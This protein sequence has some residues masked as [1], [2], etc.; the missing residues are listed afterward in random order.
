MFD[1]KKALSIGLCILLSGCCSEENRDKF[2]VGAGAFVAGSIITSSMSSPKK[3][4][5]KEKTN[6]CG[7][8]RVKTIQSIA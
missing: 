5:I 6:I 1:V 7:T 8:R 4:L 3:M 2:L